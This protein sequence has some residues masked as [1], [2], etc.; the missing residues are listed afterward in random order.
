M[1]DLNIRSAAVVPLTA[2]SRRIGVFTLTW[3][4]Q[5]IPTS[6]VMAVASMLADR[7]ALAIDNARLFANW[8]E[9]ARLREEVVGVVSHDLRNPLQ[10]ILLTERVLLDSPDE[11]PT[12]RQAKGLNRIRSAAERMN[13]LIR[14]LLDFAR[15]RGG[16]LKLERKPL[17][18]HAVVR[19]VCD[20]HLLAR[21]GRSIDLEQIGNAEGWWDEARLSQIVA[22]LVANALRYSPAESAV[23]VRCEALHGEMLLTVHNEGPPI[24]KELL[25]TLFEPFRRGAGGEKGSIGLGLYIARQAAVAHGGSISVTSSAHGGTTF[26][27]RLPRHAHETS[28]RP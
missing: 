14:G 10:A 21:P 22:N 26:K 3:A 25:P 8:K 7:A 4:E 9:A 13:Q 23:R 11:Q 19:T 20:E 5:G 6:E 18:F 15:V 2:R 28:A 17:D 12:P 27:V 24:D 1:E 16:A